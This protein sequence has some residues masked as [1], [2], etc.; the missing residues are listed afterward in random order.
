MVPHSIHCG[1]KKFL[2]KCHRQTRPRIQ[3]GAVLLHLRVKH[4]FSIG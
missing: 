1:A 3:L 2:D 4:K